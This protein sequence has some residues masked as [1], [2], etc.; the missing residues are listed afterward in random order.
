MREPP[1]PSCACFFLRPEDFL[2]VGE[3][4]PHPLPDRVRFFTPEGENVGQEGFDALVRRVSPP[5][6]LSA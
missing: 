2:T 1:C 4:D 3:S 6:R 5:C